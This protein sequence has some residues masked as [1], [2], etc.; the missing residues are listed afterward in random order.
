MPFC[1][2][3]ASARA[4]SSSSLTRRAA[5][6]SVSACSAS[7]I[8]MRRSR[9]RPPPMLESMPWICEV[10]SSI[11]GGARI[12]ICGLAA[13]TS[14]SISLSASSPSRS[15]FLNF[16]RV[17]L[18]SLAPS[19]KPTP[20]AVGISTSRMRSSAASCARVRTRFI[21]CSRVCLTLISTRSRTMVSTSRPT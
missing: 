16:W 18:S 9:R 11:P 7:R 3:L 10:S 2:A 5:S 13:A 15:F 19:W 21:A 17:A 1:S 6:S 8:F 20:L 14:M 12:S 4:F